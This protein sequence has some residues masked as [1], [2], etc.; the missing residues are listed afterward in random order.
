MN[1]RTQLNPRHVIGLDALRFIAAML[2]VAYHYGFWFWADPSPVSSPQLQHLISFPELFASTHFGWVGVQIFFVI[3]GFVI[4]FSGER[5]GGFDFLVSRVVRLGPGVW[6]CASVTLVAV[7]TAGESGLAQTLRAFLHSVLFIPIAPWIDYAYWTLGIEIVFYFLVFLLVLRGKFSWINR[8]AMVIGLAST[9]FWLAAWVASM[10]DAGQFFQLMQQLR[11]SRI[12]G[13]LLVHHGIFFALG[14]FLWLEL[15]KHSCRENRLWCVL[16]CAA[17]CLQIA[18][19]SSAT[20]ETTGT[21]FSAW[22]PVLC[23][24]AALAWIIV[25]VRRNH[26][27]HALP[28]WFLRLL[29]TA[30]MMTFPLYLLHQVA[31]AHL[32]VGLVQAGAGRWLAL[33]GALAF[34]LCGAWLVAVYCEPALQRVT[35]QALLRAGARFSLVRKAT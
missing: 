17:G 19:T 34:S 3:S 28:Q 35:K 6:I 23:W 8:L 31:G 4:A 24:L 10:G 30:G 12:L 2:V 13:L 7:V 1:Q 22:I 14:I 11:R 29:K 33:A 20:D 25:S 27:V 32:M 18:L 16:F 5:S 9:L 21:A 26:R 15:V